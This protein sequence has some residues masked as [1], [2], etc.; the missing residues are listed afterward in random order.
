MIG[1]DGGYY[2]AALDDATGREL[3][4]DLDGATAGWIA[5]AGRL[6]R[7]S[8]GYRLEGRWQFGSG[9]THADVMI[10]GAV[11]WEDGAPVSSA[12][13]RQ[14]LRVAVLRADEVDVLDTWSTTGLAGSGS[15][16]Y[17][18]DDAFVPF[19]R[20]FRLR[21][22][23]GGR[24]GTLYAWPG[25]FFANL[26]G[27]PLG[28]ARAALDATETLLHDKVLVPEMRPATHDGRVRAG[29]ANAH[30][31]VGSARSYVFDALGDLWATIEAGS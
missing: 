16:D 14:E 26:S 22:L 12:D 11:V 24:D 17:T 19:A 1:S 13:G 23:R 28:I 21:D 2:T 9:C 10:G 30:A 6:H 18:A 27:V 4:P 3:Y 7:T 25:M 20:T 5:P 15:H 29:L 8:G 31:L